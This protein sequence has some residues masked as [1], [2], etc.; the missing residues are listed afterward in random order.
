MNL[1]DILFCALVIWWNTRVYAA[2]NRRSR[3]LATKLHL[4]AIL[5]AICMVIC[6]NPHIS[7]HATVFLVLSVAYGFTQLGAVKLRV[8]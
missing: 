1:F 3:K 6:G 4:A 5:L 2:L 7:A 8:F